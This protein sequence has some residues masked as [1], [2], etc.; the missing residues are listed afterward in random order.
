MAAYGV[1]T[2]GNTHQHTH[3]H[4]HT[5][6]HTHLS[7]LPLA[8]L[9]LEDEPLAGQLWQGSG[10]GPQ[11]GRGQGGHGVRVVAA[12]TLQ[13]DDVG[14]GVVGHAGG[15]LRRGHRGG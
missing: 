1:A 4:T 12:D 11:R 7:K 9:L 10:V 8:E 2:F 5:P 13:V 6:T 14:L 15:L 3:T